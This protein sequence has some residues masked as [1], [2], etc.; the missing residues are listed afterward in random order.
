MPNPSK[1]LKHVRMYSSDCVRQETVWR[2][3]THVDEVD[4]N[5]ERHL[6]ETHLDGRV[7]ADL[8]PETPHTTPAIITY[9]HLFSYIILLTATDQ[10][11]S[12]SG[13]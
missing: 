9:A 6:D 10:Y 8:D 7:G 12:I 4:E 1:V 3:S 5:E 2:E 11:F 13:V